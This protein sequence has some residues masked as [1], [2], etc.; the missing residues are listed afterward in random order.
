M[1]HGFVHKW[2]NDR[3]RFV[4]S[5]RGRFMSGPFRIAVALGF[6]VDEATAA[7]P[8]IEAA[9]LVLTGIFAV[10]FV[11]RIVAA[12]SRTGHLSG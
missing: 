2:V 4:R 5:D 8:E 7:R 10:E 11:S 3:D 12:R 6:I 9:E 1:H